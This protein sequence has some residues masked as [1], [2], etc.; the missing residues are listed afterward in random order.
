VGF[1]RYHFPPRKHSIN[2]DAPATEISHDSATIYIH[3]TQ[4]RHLFG[5]PHELL[6]IRRNWCEGIPQLHPKANDQHQLTLCGN[7]DNIIEHLVI[8]PQ[9]SEYGLFFMH[10]NHRVR[11]E[12]LEKLVALSLSDNPKKQKILR[13]IL[14]RV[15]R[16]AKKRNDIAHGIWDKP[17]GPGSELRRMAVK[18][19]HDKSPVYSKKD[20]LR[21]R[22]EISKLENDLFFVSYPEWEKVRLPK[23]GWRKSD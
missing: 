22:D 7:V 17:P 11:R 16:A 1:E 6:H 10:P 19:D 13:N 20:L 12:M 2:P 9:E 21:I 18:P 5:V 8:V 4:Q 15:K 3:G 23:Y 14:A